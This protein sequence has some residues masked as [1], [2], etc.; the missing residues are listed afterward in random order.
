MSNEHDEGIDQV[1]QH[2]EDAW[3][4]GSGDDFAAVFAEDADFT[5]FDGVQFSGRQAIAYDHIHA[6]TDGPRMG[7]TARFEVLGVRTLAPGVVV[8]RTRATIKDLPP[9]SPGAFEPPP[10]AGPPGGGPPGGGPPGGT[11]G[12]IVALPTAVMVREDT[13]WEI[14]DFINLVYAPIPPAHHPTNRSA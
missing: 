14:V 13:G 2:L 8:V 10:G 6:F 12:E 5:V 4:R 9:G 1:I 3:N 11:P 7:S